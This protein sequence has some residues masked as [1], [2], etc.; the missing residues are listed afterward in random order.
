MEHIYS[1]SVRKRRRSKKPKRKDTFFIIASH[2]HTFAVSNRAPVEQSNEA[3]K[4]KKTKLW[5]SPSNRPLIF[6]KHLINQINI[7]NQPTNQIIA[8]TVLNKKPQET[9]LQ[10][11]KIRPLSSPLLVTGFKRTTKNSKKTEK[12]SS[13]LTFAYGPEKPRQR[14]RAPAFQKRKTPK[15]HRTLHST[16][17]LHHPLISP[18]RPGTPH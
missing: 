7:A 11:L 2:H 3:Q 5:S 6:L 13:P 18:H 9:Y 16:I 12:S 1:M 8:N 14:L 15:V 10:F 4:Q 17:S